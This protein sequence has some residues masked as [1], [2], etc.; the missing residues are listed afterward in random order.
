M[1]LDRLDHR[2]TLQVLA[3]PERCDNGVLWAPRS[4]D[5]GRPKLSVPLPRL[6]GALGPLTAA[7][8]R[9]EQMKTRPRVPWSELGAFRRLGY[10]AEVARAVS[11]HQS[12][13]EEASSLEKL[14]TVGE[15]SELLQLHTKTVKRMARDGRLPSF[16][17]AG[18]LR[19]RPSDIAS[20]LAARED[21][22]CH[23]S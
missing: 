3:D 21:R 18:R 23:G 7:P 9:E 4:R 13:R 19:F 5:R 6:G 22:A 14:L 2:A 12:P 15:L 16:R 10:R 8:G 17:V 1:I 11:S 20:W